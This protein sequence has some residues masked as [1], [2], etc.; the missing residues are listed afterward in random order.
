MNQ[1]TR[2]FHVT[3]DVIRTDVQSAAAFSCIRQLKTGSSPCGLE[4]GSGR[5][6]VRFHVNEMALGFSFLMI[7]PPFL[8]SLL[9]PLSEV[10]DGPDQA[11][12]SSHPWCGC[13][14][15]CLLN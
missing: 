6:L 8:N 4:F 1:K 2:H 11:T 5:F 9:F 12:R 10:H 15:D 13:T 14:F 3:L 7:I